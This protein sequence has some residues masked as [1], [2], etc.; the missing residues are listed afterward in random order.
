VY[1]CRENRV[2]QAKEDVGCFRDKPPRSTGRKCSHSFLATPDNTLT[3]EALK[4][5]D[6]VGE[7]LLAGFS[8]Y[9]A[10][11]YI[12]NL[13]KVSGILNFEETCD[14]RVG[15]TLCCAFAVYPF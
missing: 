10:V 3:R 2:Y 7:D 15:D 5:V 9:V 12:L 11:D 13:T 6:V 4:V 8:A 1:L 14:S